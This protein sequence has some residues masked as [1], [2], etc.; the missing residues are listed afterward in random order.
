MD[1]MMVGQQNEFCETV[2]WWDLTLGEICSNL[3]QLSRRLDVQC[4]LITW[5]WISRIVSKVDNDPN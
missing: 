4:E 5:R 3:Q 2:S 1:T